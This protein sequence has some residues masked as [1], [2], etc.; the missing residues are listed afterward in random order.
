MEQRPAAQ[1][2][3][4]VRCWCLGS[5]LLVCR[6]WQLCWLGFFFLFFFFPPTHLVF[7]TRNGTVSTLG[8]SSYFSILM[9]DLINWLIVVGFSCMLLICSLILCHS[10]HVFVFSF[11][12]FFIIVFIN[13]FFAVSSDRHS[14]S[15]FEILSKMLS[16]N[17]NFRTFWRWKYNS[18]I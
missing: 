15:W 18:V 11:V 3:L 12:R 5:A 17:S 13:L 6:S 2:F 14:G 16:R 8:E 9:L 4:C 7:L 10:Y 1:F